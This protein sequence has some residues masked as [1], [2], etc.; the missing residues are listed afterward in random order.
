VAFEEPE[1]AERAVDELNGK[2]LIEGKVRRCWNVFRRGNTM[3]LNMS[4]KYSKLS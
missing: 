3:E 4:F 1:D 2:E